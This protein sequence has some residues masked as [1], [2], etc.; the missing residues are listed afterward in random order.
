M[1]EISTH[2]YCLNCKT[3][4]PEGTDLSK[5]VYCASCGQ[6]SKDSKLSF[7]RLI[8][9][10][11]SNIFN[12]DSRLVHTFRDIFRPSKLTKSYIEGRRKYY[13]NPIRFFIFMLLALITLSLLCIKIDNRAMGTDRIYTN[14]ERSKMF[15][16]YNSLLDSIDTIGHGQIID[17]LRITLF[18]KVKSLEEDTLG[19]NGPQL[20]NWGNPTESFGISYYD[21][22]HLTQDSLF[23]KYEV[24][25]FWEKINVGQYIRVVTNPA[26]GIRYVIKNLTWAVFITVLLMSFFMKI[27]YIRRSYYLVEH[28]VLIL[29]SHSLLFLLSAINLIVLFYV[30]IDPYNDVVRPILFALTSICIMVIQ[31][32]SLK[33]YYQQGF[34]MT[35]LKQTMINFAYLF[36]FNMVVIAVAIISLI[37]Y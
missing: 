22:I 13:V 16:E 33:K 36:I 17:T 34:F 12:L 37:L 27:I 9:D 3:K 1:A 32:L 20:F 31:F 35:L 26:G 18:N 28:L 2:S 7:V 19:K 8:K 25:S 10:A 21:A 6:S 23:K 14:A 29:N 24:T 4:Y 30:D 15:D 5:E 11:V